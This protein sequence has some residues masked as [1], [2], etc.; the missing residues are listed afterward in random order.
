MTKRYL[1]VI[2]KPRGSNYSA[3]VPDLPGCI[4]TADTLEEIKQLMREGIEFHLKSMREDGHP[5]PEP[6]TLADYIEV[7]AEVLVT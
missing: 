3:F 7:P 1:V 4:A 5:I 2:E 6:T